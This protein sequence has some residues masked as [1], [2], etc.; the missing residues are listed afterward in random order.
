MA[1]WRRKRTKPAPF[2]LTLWPPLLKREGRFHPFLF[3]RE[4]G[5]GDEFKRATGKNLAL[6]GVLFQFNIL[7][8]CSVTRYGTRGDDELPFAIFFKEGASG[9]VKKDA[10]IT[11]K[12]FF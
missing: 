2:E 8:P 1:K 6:F 9:C 7:S 4:G 10:D 11:T 12:Y 5:W 3:S